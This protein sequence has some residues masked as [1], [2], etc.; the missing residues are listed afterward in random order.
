M[1]TDR[2]KNAEIYYGLGERIKRGLLLLKDSAVI[3]SAPG[4]YEVEGKDMYYN[5]DSYQTMP[6]GQGRFEAHRRYIDIQ[7]IVSGRE[8]IGVSGLEGLKVQ[9]PYNPAE[10]VEFYHQAEPMSRVVLSAGDFAIFRPGDAH[11]PCRMFD[12]P[13]QVRKIVVKVSVEPVG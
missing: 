3:N 1:I 2:L 6:A 4:R 13:E 5:S 9:T 7:Y 8:W 12:R 11:M 10:D